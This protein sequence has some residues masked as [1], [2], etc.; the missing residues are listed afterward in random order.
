MV[1]TRENLKAWLR[2]SLTPGVGNI[3]ARSLLLGF[4]LP[5]AI[6]ER[7]ALQ[8]QAL[9][10]ETISLQL[11]RIPPEL[12]EAVETTWAWLHTQTHSG[13]SKI[14]NKRL[15]TLADPDYPS[16][17][18]LTPDPPCLLYVLGQTQHLHLLSPPIDQA[19]PAL[20][21]VGSRNPTPQGRLNAHDF[22]AHLAQAGLTVVS[23][24]AL[25]VD[26]A[27]HQGALKGGHASH[28]LHTIAVVG[29]GLDRVYPYQNHA[30]ALKIAANGLLISEYPLNTPP[31]TSNFPKRNR[32]IAGLSQG[33]LVVEAATRSGSLITAK[34][35]L[36]LGKEVFAIPGSIHTTVSK[37]CHDLIKQGAKLVDCTQDILEELKN[38]PNVQSSKT[39]TLPP[40]L[41]DASVNLL[42]PPTVLAHLGQ[43]PVGLDELQIRSGL[44]V[45]QLQTELFQLELNGLLGRLPGGLYQKLNRKI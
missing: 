41:S 20:A 7:S 36:D 17:L 2:L 42:A 8:L 38:L 15:L 37:G 44:S 30:L 21:V 9:V 32:L 10:S 5:E 29:T 16:S 23:G 24:L 31:I 34:Q 11:C 19:P 28:P 33:C 39:S 22:A 35:A 45:A 26:T 18:M 14:L 6:F 43:D 1:S 3:T 27:A 25:G 13:S 40:D 12:D 4:G